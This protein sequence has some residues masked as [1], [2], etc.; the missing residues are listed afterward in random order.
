[1]KRIRPTAVIADDHAAMRDLVRR[2]LLPRFDVVASATDGADL[3]DAWQ[4]HRPDL[5]V[6]DVDMPR[7]NGI[8]AV[9]RIRGLGGSSIV[10]I[11]TVSDDRDLAEAALEAG[12][13]AYVVKTRIA[14]DLF[15][16]IDAAL[17]GG[18]FVSQLG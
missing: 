12:A 7:L 8:E 2:M 6:V 4:A 10:V 5:L 9:R 17:A 18:S 16:A 14:S 15:D 1:M 11:L 3:I 13:N